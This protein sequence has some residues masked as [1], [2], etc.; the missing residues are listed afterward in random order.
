MPELETKRAEI[1][2]SLNNESDYEKIS[3]LSA[4]L[5]AISEKLENHELRWL[6]LQ[7]MLGEG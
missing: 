4:D 2:D 6:E 7:E 3:K 1:L 5:E